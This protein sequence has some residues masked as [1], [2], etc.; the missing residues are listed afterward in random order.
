MAIAIEELELQTAEYLPNREVMSGGCR[1]RKS[2]CE[3]Q[4][5]PDPCNNPCGPD[6][7][8]VITV[9]LSIL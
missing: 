1:R 8:G 2:E 4:C 3:R 9:H 5:E 7:G 6:D